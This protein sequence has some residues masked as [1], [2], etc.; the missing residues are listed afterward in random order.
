[1]RT[2]LCAAELLWSSFWLFTPQHMEQSPTVP[3]F[4]VLLSDRR[5]QAVQGAIYSIFSQLQ[6]K[7]QCR[8]ITAPCPHRGPGQVS[9]QKRPTGILSVCS[10]STLTPC[11]YTTCGSQTHCLLFAYF[12]MEFTQALEPFGGDTKHLPGGCAGPGML[13]LQG[14]GAAQGGDG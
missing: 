11:P 8:R 14:Q 13:W 3:P 10:S 1:M 4:G 6:Q 7:P 2:R 12:G 5:H 9:K